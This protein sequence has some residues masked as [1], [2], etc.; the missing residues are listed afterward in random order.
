M[1]DINLLRET[2]EAFEKACNLKRVKIDISS[3]LDLDKKVR[4]LKREVEA[5]RATQNKVSKEIPKLAK[6]EKEQ[7]LGEMKLLSE[8]LK[9]GGEE[10]T[11][12]EHEL[13]QLMIRLPSIPLTKV[14]DGSDDS[15]NVEI[16]REGVMPNFDFEAK[17]HVTLAKRLD[18]LDIERGVKIA[19][20]RNYFLKG[21]GAL[22][23]RAVLSLAI[24][25][26]VAKG[27]TIMDVPH[28]V[29]YAAMEGTSYFPGGEEQ[30]YALDDRD[31]GHYLIGT[32][33][34][35]VTSYHADEILSFEELPKR[36]AGYSACYRR[37]SGTYGK[38][39]QGIY[40]IH[41]FYK[42]EQVVVC[43]G[44]DES[45]AI[46][47]AEL[48]ANA[49]DLLKALGLHYRVVDVCSG[50]MGLGQVYKNDIESWMPSRKNFGETHSCSTFHDF[51]AR[52]LNLRYRD[53]DQ[54]IKFCHTLNN[55]CVA[56]PRILIPIL[57]CNQQRDGSI[58]IPKALRPYMFGKEL[59][60]PM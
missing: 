17:D 49:E 19:G 51:Q 16:R 10:L 34:V 24:D 44:D 21:D 40:R 18:I 55:T 59:I 26:L 37:E 14:P 31:E 3:I 47:H 58:V 12:L 9:L 38:D 8:K 22:L 56:S 46:F 35:S 33:E 50:D 5:L 20:A 15:E 52:R 36:Y 54:K 2:P 32:A 53:K 11:H 28:L 1:I 57:E 23:Q 43:E 4:T 30:A 48:L 39:T 7:K 41:Q 13:R 42:V 29:R 45:S 25:Q 6:E 27:Y 60:T